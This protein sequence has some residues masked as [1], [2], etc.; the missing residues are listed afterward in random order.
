MLIPL[1]ASL[2]VTFVA[3]I[4]IVGGALA[5]T[6]GGT[7]ASGG[8]L[9]GA[10]IAAIV[11]VLLAALVLVAV[12]VKT[13]GMLVQLAAETERGARPGFGDL[14]RATKGI[15][16]RGL[17]IIVA[18]TV[19]SVAWYVLALVALAATLGSVFDTGEMPAASGGAI[20]L[21][22]LFLL[23]S[24]VGALFL[25][26][27]WI[28]Y[29]QALAL[30]NAGGLDPLR[31]SWRLTKGHFWRT[32]GWLLLVSVLVLAVYLV[33]MGPLSLVTGASPTGMG[34][35]FD[36]TGEAAAGVGVLS[37]ALSSLVSTVLSLLVGPFVSIFY[38]VMY[39][40]QRRRKGETTPGGPAA[41]GAFHG[42][43]FETRPYDEVPSDR[44]GRPGDG[45][46]GSPPSGPS[47]ER[48]ET[49][50]YGQYGPP[51]TGDAPW[52]QPGDSHGGAAWPSP[53]AQRNDPPQSSPR[54]EENPPTA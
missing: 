50:R 45:Q 48:P 37:S 29:G 30:E 54:G 2:V 46:H 28:Y 5:V 40:D 26:V 39:L 53:P 13:N 15:V 43:Q 34:P 6:S 36:P 23:V 47:G 49:P 52:N 35:A 11:V 25:G 20:A 31:R 18:L 51:P 44:L 24:L 19:L 8:L 1:V 38:T 21:F 9:T 12:T 17:L 7:E 33:I 27:K 42:S 10:V 16:R 14:N 41:V 22:G 32:L 4:V 3:V